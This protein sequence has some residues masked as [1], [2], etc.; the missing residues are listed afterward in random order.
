VESAPVRADAELAFVP[1]LAW[2]PPVAPPAGAPVAT[3]PAGALAVPLV[4]LPPAAV[5]VPAAALVPAAAPVPALPPV[6][7]PVAE[8]RVAAPLFSGAMPQVSQ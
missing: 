6:V 3:P 7:P 5:P 1:R 4:A 2:V 8:L